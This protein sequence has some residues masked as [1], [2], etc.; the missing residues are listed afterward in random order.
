MP[1][2]PNKSGGANYRSWMQLTD[3]QI[4]S[5]QAIEGADKVDDPNSEQFA[6]IVHL[7][8]SS[9]NVNTGTSEINVNLEGH[10]CLENTTNTPLAADEVFTGSGFQDMKDY[11]MLTISVTADVDSAT[12]G[13][14]IQWSQDGVTAVDADVF[15][16]LGGISKTFTFGPAHRYYRVKYTNGGSDQTDFHLASVIRRTYVKPSSHRIADNIVGDDDAE[17]VK[18]VLTGIKP[19]GTFDNANLTQKKNLKVSLDE[20][21]DSTAIDAFDRLRVSEPYTI[22]DSKQIH[23]KQPLFWD[24]TTGGSATSAHSTGNACTVMTVTANAADY[25]IRQTRQRFNYQPGK[26]QLILLTYH[27]P[28]ETDVTKR[29]GLFS[30]TG[31]NNLT[32]NNGIFFETDGTVSWNIAKNGTTTESVSQANWNIDPMDGTGPSLLTL[33]TDATQ[34]LIIDFE[35]LGVGRVRVGFVIDG[36]ITY[37]H[38]FNHAN[39][40]TFTSVYM[41][42]P[43]L[44][45]RYDIQSEGGAGHIDH[46]CSTVMSEGGVEE[47]GVLRSISNNATAVACGTAGTKYALKGMRLKSTY[48]DVTVTPVTCTAISASNANF[49]WELILNP[50]VAG[51]FTYTDLTNS[52]IQQATGVGTNT[53]TGG[54]IISSGYAG[55]G[56]AQAQELQTALRMG[57]T[58]A[59]VADTLVL[60]ATPLTNN[61]NIYGT[62]T[63]REL[64]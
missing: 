5:I 45:V 34:I 58:I 39:D 50:T 36:L 47:N 51:T 31:V 49:L 9:N 8:Q 35:W 4:A 26:S 60:V 28:Q 40:P 27:S 13:L 46:I 61:M 20:F 33:D 16:I 23:D 41:S 62:L 14:E 59:G 25:V 56:I 32:P 30:G 29:V 1:Y 24:E 44:P 38:E 57:T 18:A 7:S 17:L 6:Q 2:N 64:L 3:A 52:A 12:D 15:T 48:N 42:T 10:E 43:N 55:G 22:F 63:F 54:T 21:G 11:G 19:D 37:V 53:V